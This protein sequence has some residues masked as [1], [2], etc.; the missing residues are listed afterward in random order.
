ME[1][2]KYNMNISFKEKTDIQIEK[3]VKNIKCNLGLE[4]KIQEGNEIQSI[5]YKNLFYYQTFDVVNYL[6]SSIV[7]DQEKVSFYIEPNNYKK[8]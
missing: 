8:N 6:F 1:I 5:D 4:G 3:I 2:R 7:F